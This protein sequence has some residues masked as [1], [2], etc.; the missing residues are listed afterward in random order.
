MFFIVTPYLL[1]VTPHLLLRDR[2][3]I[4]AVIPLSHPLFLASL[5]KFLWERVGVRVS[6]AIRQYAFIPHP[7]PLPQLSSVNYRIV[8]GGRGGSQHKLCVD[9]SAL[10]AG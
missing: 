10:V 5:L 4:Y 9:P 3:I 1:I 7:S 8:V 6:Q 2:R